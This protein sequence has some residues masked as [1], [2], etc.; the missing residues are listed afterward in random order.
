MSREHKS[1]RPAGITRTAIFGATLGVALLGSSVSVLADQIT[2]WSGY[3]EMAPFYQHVAEGLKAQ[4]PDLT[5]DVEAIGLRD[6]EKRVAL[7]ISS[8]NAADVIELATSSATRY[9]Q[10]DLLQHPPADIASYVQDPA[11]FDKYF[12]DAASYNGQVYGAPLFRGQSA[13]YYNTDMFK[14]A[15]LTEPPKTMDDYTKY[16]AKLAQRD[17]NGNL[18][19]S[20]WSMRLSGGGQ[21]IAE[22]FWI[23]MFQY[24]GNV[25]VQQPDGKWKMTLATPEGHKNLAQYI[26]VVHGDKSDTIEAPADSDAFERGQTA[27]FIRESWVIGDIAKKAPD[28]NYATSTLPMGSIVSPVNLFVGSEQHSAEAW[29][30]VKAATSPENQLWMLENVGWLPNHANLDYTE[31]LK[32]TPQFAAFVQLPKDY[33][34]FQLPNI[35]PADEFLTRIAAKLTDSFADASLLNNDAGIDAALQSA[36]DDGAAVL[37]RAGILAK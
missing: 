14:A 31:I 3:P 17:A 8:Q 15:G 28:L 1:E 26:Q 5:V 7:G 25:V 30:F 12:S 21:G 27:M 18:T 11:N 23:N 36:S 37:D 16:A 19:V 9:M 20:G 2:V 13:L 35:G 32:K 33:K 22:K 6:H 24:G 4:F 10:E 34:F 29:A